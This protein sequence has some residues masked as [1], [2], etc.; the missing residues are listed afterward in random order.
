MK[1]IARFYLLIDDQGKFITTKLVPN[2][3]HNIKLLEIILI[4][5]DLN[6]MIL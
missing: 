4:V 5:K 1:F 2:N 6:G 3:I